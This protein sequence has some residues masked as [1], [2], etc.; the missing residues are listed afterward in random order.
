M[1][2]RSDYS[3]MIVDDVRSTC[4]ATQGILGS[5]D[6]KKVWH[7]GNGHE[8]LS[9]LQSEACNVDCIISDYNMPVMDGL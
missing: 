3:F 8:A 7:A 9:M 6:F 2:T 1:K 5:A 4:I